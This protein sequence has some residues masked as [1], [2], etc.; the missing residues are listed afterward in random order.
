LLTAITANTGKPLSKWELGAAFQKLSNFGLSPEKITART[1]YG[2]RFIREALELADAPDEIKQLLSSQAVTPSLALSQLRSNAT[3]A[4]QIQT[5]QKAAVEA[6]ASGKKGPAKRAKKPIMASKV[7]PPV[8]KAPAHA[9]ALC[10]EVMAVLVELMQDVAI[11]E[12]NDDSVT[13]VQVDKVLLLK[14]ASFAV[15][16]SDLAAVSNVK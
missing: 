5:L 9:P 1:G 8:H 16:D 2:E 3:K 10:A 7:A 15:T 4:V 12:L 6:K 11:S 14:L 13:R